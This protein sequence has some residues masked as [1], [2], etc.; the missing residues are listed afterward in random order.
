MRAPAERIY[1]AFLDPTAM[2][3][4]LPPHGFTGKITEINPE[5]GGIYKM[6]FTNFTTQQTHSFGGRYLE[7]VP[8][9][10]IR[11]DDQFD[12]PSMPGIIETTIEFEE[13]AVGTWVTITQEGIPEEIPVEFATMGWQESI[14]LLMKLVEPE[15]PGTVGPAPDSPEVP[16][17]P[18]GGQ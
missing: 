16:E 18:E 12:D 7:L 9:K 5:V 6:S 17:V 13:V 14:D 10:L 4:W 1:R 3:K 2:V 11:Y 15:I 8:Y